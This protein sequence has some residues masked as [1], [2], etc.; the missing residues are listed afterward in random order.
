M[1]V[2]NCWYVQFTN[3]ENFIVFLKEKLLACSFIL[4]CNQVFVPFDFLLIFSLIYAVELIKHF[5]KI[6]VTII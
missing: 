6:V 1:D 4:I 2:K 5:V 3:V